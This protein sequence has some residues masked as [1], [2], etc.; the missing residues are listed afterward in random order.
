MEHKVSTSSVTY[1]R[2]S[3]DVDVDHGPMKGKSKSIKHRFILI[4]TKAN[5]QKK[6]ENHVIL[7]GGGVRRLSIQIRNRQ[8][9]WRPGS[10]REDPPEAKGNSLQL[11]PRLTSDDSLSASTHTER[12]RPA[13]EDPSMRPGPATLD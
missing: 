3:V 1:S 4:K 9:N 10:L 11:P 12:P 7:Q 8:G 5:T 2:S 6:Q 13:S